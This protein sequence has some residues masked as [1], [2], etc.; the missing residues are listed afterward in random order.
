MPPPQNF[1]EKLL[2]ASNEFA[3]QKTIAKNQ[4]LTREGQVEKN[5]FYIETGAVRVFRLTEFEE[6]TIR[7]GYRGS[8]INSLYSFFKNSPSEF[9]IETIRRTTVMIMPKEIIL[10]FDISIYPYVY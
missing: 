7:F 6:Q 10:S 3:D 9:Y 2:T 8:F 1:I 5:L 4:F